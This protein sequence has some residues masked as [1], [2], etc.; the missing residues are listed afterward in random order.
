[1]S[2]GPVWING[3]LTGR[4]DPSDRG[5]TL[6]DGVFDTALAL[7][8]VPFAASRHMKR[9][10]SQAEAI[11][12]PVA[13]AGLRAGWEA[14]LAGA[15]AEEIVL[16]TT[17]T[18]GASARALWPSASPDPTII[19]SAAAWNR[20]LFARQLR[21]VTSSI[22][23]NPGSPTSRLKTLGYLDNILGAREAAER[24]ADDALFLNPLGHVACTTIA[25]LF[26]VDGERLLTP[27]LS[28]GVQPGIMRA[29]VLESAHAAGL[30]PAEAP[31]RV[32]DLRTADAVFLTNSVR[33]L[34]DV[35]ELDGRPLGRS[36][37][38]KVKTLLAAIAGQVRR[39]CG[40]D[41]RAPDS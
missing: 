39:E 29:L 2:P 30:R 27:P 9:L 22:L 10:V 38:G 31:L 19:V 8:R 23:R 21:L 6:G 7:R 40:V 13:E 24:G 28:D 14:V 32:A 17:V 5:L 4:I 11:G 15:E 34:S 26:A 25:N 3:S 36:G 20:S 37:A 1:M 12:I 35:V 41:P 18:R 16:R 33:F